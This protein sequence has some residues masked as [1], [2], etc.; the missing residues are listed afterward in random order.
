MATRRTG[1]RAD[2]RD[3]WWQ[4]DYAGVPGWGLVAF[5]VVFLALGVLIAY[6]MLNPR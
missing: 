3:P 2:G 4:R 1:H 5:G 6:L